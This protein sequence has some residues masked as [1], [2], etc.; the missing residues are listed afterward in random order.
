M[1][2]MPSTL[3]RAGLARVAGGFP[4]S[5]E[6]SRS[7]WLL[8]VGGLFVVWLSRRRG[9]RGK[10]GG[11]GGWSTLTISVGTYT[12]TTALDT[13]IE[14]FLSGDGPMGGGARQIVSLGA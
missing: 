8:W 4:L 11:G 10:E 14:S 2:R 7:V 5:T 1:T 6:V 3:C 9:G 13:L 12:R